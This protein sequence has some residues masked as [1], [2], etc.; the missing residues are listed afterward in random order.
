MAA[1]SRRK[2]LVQSALAASGLALPT[3]IPASAL[4]KDGKPAPSERI[5]LG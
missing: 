1:S 3:I 4:G 5:T 2:F